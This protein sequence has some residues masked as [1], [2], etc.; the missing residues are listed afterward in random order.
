MADSY[1]E[2]RLAGRLQ[3]RQAPQTMENVVTYDAVAT[4]DNPHLHLKPGMTAQVRF[5]IDRQDDVLLVPTAAFPPSGS[6]SR[7]PL[8]HRPAAGAGAPGWAP[9]GAMGAAGASQAGQGGYMP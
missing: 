5:V 2:Q 8:R 4:T 3:I 1:P 9:G 6:T 7:A